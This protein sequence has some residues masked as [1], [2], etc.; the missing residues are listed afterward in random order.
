MAKQEFDFTKAAED[1]MAAFKID[2]KAFDD[3][4]K[5][6]AEFN[7]KL[8]TVALDA[9]KKNAELTTAWTT[10]TLKAA[11]AANKVQKDPADYAKVAG[12]FATAQFQ[13]LP[14]KLSAYV[15]V[16]RKAQLDSVELFAAAGKSVQDE[17]TAKAK[18][19]QAKAKAA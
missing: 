3:A 12:D 11:E 1:F 4:T 19:V 5:S 16:A 9:A 17:V 2:P 18:E 6:A 15:E 8:A 10:E 13:A 7:A 14:E